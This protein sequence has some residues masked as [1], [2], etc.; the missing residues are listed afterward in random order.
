M[1][2]GH[3][4]QRPGNSGIVEEEDFERRDTM[5]R[6]INDHSNGGRRRKQDG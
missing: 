2:D 3:R 6:T 5:A 4:G 1:V